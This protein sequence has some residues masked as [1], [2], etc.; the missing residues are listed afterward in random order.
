MDGPPPLVAYDALPTTAN[1]DEGRRWARDAALMVL[2]DCWD[3]SLPI[4]LLSIMEQ[5]DVQ[6]FYAT[7]DVSG[8]SEKIRGRRPK[9]F[10]NREDSSSRQRFT[11][12]HELGHIVANGW[13]ES[14]AEGQDDHRDTSAPSSPNEYAMNSLRRHCSCPSTFFG[15]T[16][17]GVAMVNWQRCSV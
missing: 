7:L 3:G 8:R 9:L 2:E 6:G 12:A 17:K 14:A 1:W 5:L 4:P 11:I 16:R 15:T 13:L 10:I